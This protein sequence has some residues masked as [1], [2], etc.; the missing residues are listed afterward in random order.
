M[1]RTLAMYAPV[2]YDREF[3]IYVK[4]M[5]HLI[6]LYFKEEVSD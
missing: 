5:S 4:D 6:H 2:L 3:E 1:E